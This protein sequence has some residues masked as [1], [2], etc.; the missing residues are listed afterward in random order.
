MEL[1][2][3]H[4]VWSIHRFQYYCCI[5]IRIIMNFFKLDNFKI[6]HL[7]NIKVYC[8]RIIMILLIPFIGNLS[9]LYISDLEG[10][11]SGTYVSLAI[12]I[13]SIFNIVIDNITHAVSIIAIVFGGLWI[14]IILAIFL[15][16]RSQI[17][18]SRRF[19]EGGEDFSKKHL[20]KVIIANRKIWNSVSFWSP[21]LIALLLFGVTYNFGPIPPEQVDPNEAK[22]NII[23]SIDAKMEEKGYKFLELSDR[24]IVIK[25]CS[26]Q[27][28][29]KFFVYKDKNFDSKMYVTL[30]CEISSNDNNELDILIEP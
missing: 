30:K 6:Q 26:D 15:Y 14:A 18:I 25:D 24:E 28:A 20:E 5:R 9:F 16:I 1:Y 12:L 22:N 23:N 10:A 3:G 11:N 2:I 7:C 29:S 17:V 13:S 19:E 27:Q 8:I 21:V 4:M